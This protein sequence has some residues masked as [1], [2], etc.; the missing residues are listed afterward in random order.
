MVFGSPNPCGVPF[1]V[2]SNSGAGT[3]LIF[4]LSFASADYA[5]ACGLAIG[6]SA[7]FE[8]CVRA[9]GWEGS[10]LTGSGL[11]SR[12]RGRGHGRRVLS[13]ARRKIQILPRPRHP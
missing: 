3:M 9:S 5:D 4:D 11:V 10:I 7:E 6:S 8:G 2:Y 13:L 12:C 1:F